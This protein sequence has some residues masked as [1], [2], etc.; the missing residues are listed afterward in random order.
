VS[1]CVGGGK[2]EVR[3]RVRLAAFCEEVREAQAA[4]FVVPYRRGNRGGR[5]P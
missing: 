1:A 5:M 3:E 2:V 4:P